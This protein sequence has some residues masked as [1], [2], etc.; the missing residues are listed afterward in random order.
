MANF[1]V[2]N[3]AIK[4]AF[5]NLD[6]EVVRGDGYVYFDSKDG[7]DIVESIMTNPTT[8]NT[9]TLIRMCIE[10]IEDFYG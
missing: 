3:K 10:N 6:I 4:K 5:P 9:D 2:V 1:K 7:L 8:T